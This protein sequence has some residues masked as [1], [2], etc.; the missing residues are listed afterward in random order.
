MRQ[1][2]GKVS[3]I[4]VPFFNQLTPVSSVKDLGLTLDSHLNF[5]DHVN[6]LTSSLLSMLCQISRVRHIF[7]KSFL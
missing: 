4:R 5:N 2:L 7:T 1:L 6:M 3:D